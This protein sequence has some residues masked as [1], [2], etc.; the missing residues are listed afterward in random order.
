M[1]TMLPY[2]P[3]PPKGY[4]APWFWDFLSM[5]GQERISGI[6]S[7]LANI[8]YPLAQVHSKEELEGLLHVSS[9]R[10]LRLKAEMQE[11]LKPV[12]LAKPAEF[13]SNAHDYIRKVI[14]AGA[15]LLGEESLSRMLGTIDSIEGLSNW[16]NETSK[17]DV[18]AIYSVATVIQQ[19]GEPVLYTDICM[20]TLMAV[21][22]NQITDWIPEAIPMLAEAADDYMTEVEDVFLTEPSDTGAFEEA[23]N[24]ESLRKDLG[25]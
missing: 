25:L 13:S 4:D 11:L 5:A 17:Q 21:L 7:T 12:V 15:D 19:I 2:L 10:F 14:F 20:S 1:V 24:Y 8:L 3:I 22:M 6:G 9:H 16:M 23:V 18:S